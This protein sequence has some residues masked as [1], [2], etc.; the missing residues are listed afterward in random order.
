M[1]LMPFL[2][3]VGFP[4]LPNTAP[5]PK[6]TLLGKGAGDRSPA[7]SGLGSGPREGTSVQTL[8]LLVCV[9]VGETLWVS[10]SHA[11]ARAGIDRCWCGGPPSWWRRG[12]RGGLPRP[13]RPLS[14]LNERKGRGH[15]RK[16]IL[17]PPSF[18]L[19][20]PGTP[21]PVCRRLFASDS[22][23]SN[24]SRKA[25]KRNPPQ[26]KWMERLSSSLST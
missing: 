21:T 13:A 6:L 23:F 1:I 12:R 17:C 3:G 25:G 26:A 4:P 20:G 10:V 2:L 15:I 24:S 19:H 5:N 18:P 7:L 22:P 9:G 14:S 8:C 16:E 11:R